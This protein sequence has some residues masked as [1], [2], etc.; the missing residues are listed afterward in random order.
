M[1]YVVWLVLDGSSCRGGGGLCCYL[2]IHISMSG[3]DVAYSIVAL[4]GRLA[5]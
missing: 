5:T 2:V 1:I 3:F 4:A